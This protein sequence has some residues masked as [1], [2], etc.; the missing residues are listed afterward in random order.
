MTTATLNT[1]QETQSQVLDIMKQT[2]PITPACLATQS[3]L[4]EIAARLW[5]ESQVAARMLVR[6]PKTQFYKLA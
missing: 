1:Q 2:G 6:G 4:S 5:L 3:G